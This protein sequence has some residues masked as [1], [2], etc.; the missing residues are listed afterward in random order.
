M[1]SDGGNWVAD[2]RS[3]IDDRWSLD[4]RP[5]SS[6]PCDPQPRTH[7]PRNPTAWR[8]VFLQPESISGDW[9]NSRRTETSSAQFSVKPKETH[10]PDGPRRPEPPL[11]VAGPSCTIFQWLGCDFQWCFSVGHQRTISCVDFLCWMEIPS[12]S[13]FFKFLWFPFRL[14]LS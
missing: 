3:W 5:V 12:V 4:P 9:G 13:D 1:F 11:L 10:W 7:D 14:F 2:G 6:N 8:L